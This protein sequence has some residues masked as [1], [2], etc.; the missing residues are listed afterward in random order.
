MGTLFDYGRTFIEHFISNYIIGYTFMVL[1]VQLYGLLT[2]L[3][4]KHHLSLE[5]CKH[6]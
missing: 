2:A 4:H 6:N 1:F 5:P 3:V